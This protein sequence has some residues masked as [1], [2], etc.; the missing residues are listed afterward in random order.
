MQDPRR[1]LD[2]A[3]GRTNAASLRASDR[4]VH[5]ARSLKARLQ[6]LGTVPLLTG[7]DRMQDRPWTPRLSLLVLPAVSLA[8]FDP[9][10][11][12]PPSPLPHSL[13]LFLSLSLLLTAL[14]FWS[15]HLFTA[16]HCT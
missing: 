11:P 9:S 1:K 12:L 8:P 4:I 10:L 16:V 5:C 7:A 2:E 15:F 3:R 14:S 13:S 6:F